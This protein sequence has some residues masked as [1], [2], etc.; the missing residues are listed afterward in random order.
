M[1]APHFFENVPG[2]GYTPASYI[3]NPLADRLIVIGARRG[4]E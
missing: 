2:G 3:L 1:A 4:I